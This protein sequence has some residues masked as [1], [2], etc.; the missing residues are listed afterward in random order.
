MRTT[1]VAIP[2]LLALAAGG[3]RA[4]RDGL[5]LSTAPQ[6]PPAGGAAYPASSVPGEEVNPV[7]TARAAEA[8]AP[9]PRP[10]APAPAPV[11][12]TRDQRE[13]R[14]EARLDD[15]DLPLP[16]PRPPMTA[17]LEGPEGAATTHLVNT[18]L[19]EVNG[20]VITRED[21]FGPLRT[22]M[23]QWRKGLSPDAFEA[24][25]RHVID[26]RLRQAISQRLVLQEAKANL[27]DKE[28]QELEASL[29]QEIKDMT[30]EAGSKHALEEQLKARGT[31]LDKETA[32]HRDRLM[33]QK[34]LRSRVAPTVHVTHGQL[35]A[36]YHEVCPERYVQPARVRLAL[37]Q[38]RKADAA[39]ADQARALAQAVHARAKAGE[40]FA[41]LAQRFSQDPMA[42]QGGDWGL[43]TRGAFRVRE[44]D[45]ALFALPAGAVAPLVE[46]GDAFYVVKAAERQDARTV[47]FTEVQDALEDELRDRMYNEVV[48]RYIQQL[49][50]R[51]YVR[52]VRENL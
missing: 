52:L 40:D 32:A 8:A 37:I 20:E 41:R 45:D 1:W 17:T 30:A 33:V 15:V 4:G 19:A 31:D 50:E 5:G 26:L 14:Y 25:C 7:T 11:A 42:A 35:L 28:K 10:G 18:V 48:S 34:Y 29:T 51:A 36:F 21:I 9:T 47:P 22:Q 12:V 3:C 16:R 2:M 49:Y 39:S 43:V 46:T 38:L 6:P 23:E 27:E 44:V 13:A 24:R